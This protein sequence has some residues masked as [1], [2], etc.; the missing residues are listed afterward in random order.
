M[1]LLSYSFV[2]VV[3][4]AFSFAH[5]AEHRIRSSLLRKRALDGY[6]VVDQAEG[7]ELGCSDAQIA[8][9]HEAVVEAKYLARRASDVL[10]SADATDST[11]YLKWFGKENANAIM[12]T[13]I[14]ENNYDPVANVKSPY[15][16]NR[17]HD[18]N[19][20]AL[21]PT[22]L[23]FVCIPSDFSL[24]AP[25]AQA[26]AFQTGS[27]SDNTGPLVTLCPPFFKSVKWQAMVDDWR[28]SGKPKLTPGFALLHELQH[29]PQIT[30]DARRC[31]DVSNYAPAPND[32]GKMCYHPYCCEHIDGKDKVQ[33]AQNMAFFA[34]DV[35]VNRF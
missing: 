32:V 12:R 30:G 3:L 18:A 6:F 4:V 9:L 5:R 2:L 28:T 22:G 27:I 14:K 17:I 11:A 24:C 25:G 15:E 13:E 35:I 29:I 19:L 31:T 1:K 33:N 21:S 23:T 10:A 20:A 8:T 26:I 7:D 34:L 16:R